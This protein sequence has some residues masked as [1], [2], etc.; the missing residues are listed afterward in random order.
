MEPFFSWDPGLPKLRKEAE[1]SVNIHCPL[2][3]A[4]SITCHDRMFWILDKPF[5]LS[6]ASSCIFYHN[7]RKET[8]AGG[9][10]RR[11]ACL[12][13]HEIPDKGAWLEDS[14]HG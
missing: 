2:L 11:A 4:V 9:M 13:C 12:G 6:V 8:K 5:L 14:C 10:L 7:N 3:T 1:Q